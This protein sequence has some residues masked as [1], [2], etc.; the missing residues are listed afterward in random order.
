MDSVI[1]CLDKKVYP[2]F[3]ENRIDIPERIYKKLTELEKG[4]API[5]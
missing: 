5:R 4:I 3:Q 2:L 1:A